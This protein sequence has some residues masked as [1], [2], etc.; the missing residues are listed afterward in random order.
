MNLTTTLPKEDIISLLKL[1]TID[2]T[3]KLQKEYSK[4]EFLTTTITGVFN[5]NISIKAVYKKQSQKWYAKFSDCMF[6]LVQIKVYT[7]NDVIYLG[8]NKE[9]SEDIPYE[10]IL[11][12]IIDILDGVAKG[13]DTKSLKGIFESFVNITEGV[14]NV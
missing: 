9:S 1:A 8:V 11:C 10:V 7:N 13:G 12:D 4:G 2:T 3:Y 14:S 5:T 6:S